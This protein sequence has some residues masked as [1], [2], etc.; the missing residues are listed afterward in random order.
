MIRSA[1]IPGF[2]GRYL[3]TDEGDVVSLLSGRALKPWLVGRGYASVALV[4]ANG[5]ISKHYVH[6]IVAMAFLGPPPKGLH[7]NHID[8]DRLNNRPSNLE[9]VTAAE[10]NRHARKLGLNKSRPAVIRGEQKWNC[11]I[12]DAQLRAARIRRAAGERL[13]DL[14]AELGV[15]KSTLCVAIKNRTRAA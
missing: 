7:V 2:E 13:I 6:R 1:D 15:N 8:G 11:K 9:Y 5:D 4:A 10:N 12:S 14:A 3:V